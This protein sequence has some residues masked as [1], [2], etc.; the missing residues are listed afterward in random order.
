MTRTASVEDMEHGEI[1]IV[2]AL[3]SVHDK[4]GLAELATHLSESGVEI[5]SSGG[6]AA[7]IRAAGVQ[8]RD[9][10]EITGHP[11]FLGGRVKTLHPAI[12][13]GLLAVRGDRGH[14]QELL[15][16]GIGRFDLVVAN[17]YPFQDSQTG[18]DEREL[19]EL[20]DIGGPAM[21]RAAAKN[22][23]AVAAVTEP[24]QY[25]GLV[26]EM[27]SCGGC[28]SMQYRRERAAEAFALTAAYDAAVAEWLARSAGDVAP[29]RWS[30][31][32]ELERGLRYGEN[33]HQRAWLYRDAGWPAESAGL[34][35]L[36]GDPAGY[37][38]YADANAA[39]ELLGEFACS[40]EPACVIMKHGTPCG[41][42][43][44]ASAEAAYR[45]AL[46]CDRLSAFGGVVG[47]NCRLD[48]AAADAIAEAFVE[49]VIAPGYDDA[50]LLLLA[51]KSRARLMAFETVPAERGKLEFRQIA[52]GCLV[53]ERDRRDVEPEDLTV[54]TM[55]KPTPAELSDMLFAWK[56]AK[57]A[58]SNAVVLA[59]DGIAVGIGAGHT[60]RVEAAK[61]AGR[62]FRAHLEVDGGPADSHLGLSAASD[63]FFPFPDGLRAAAEAGASAIVQPGGSRRDDEVIEAADELG[64]AMAFT[65]VRHFRH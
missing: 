13:G 32:F 20:I 21:V 5:V 11:E 55:R 38:N 18:A 28:T 44:S 63:G 15:R 37:N 25:S 40:G 9:V 22:H 65:G 27:G 1:R 62:M 23:V 53:Q 50:A 61:A 10:S 49:V 47:L 36:E 30:V 41:A 19:T 35:Q 58:R 3:I 7:A 17:F 6:T 39:I 16:L 8:V 43:Q 33:P 26:E 46:S 51:K 54:R 2:R 24:A 14:D 12:H 29:R 64:I 34:R 60:S 4:S 57:H 56:V 42:A 59:K 48:E 45:A 52:G 31:S